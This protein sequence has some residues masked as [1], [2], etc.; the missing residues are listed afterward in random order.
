[1]IPT[2]LTRATLW[3]ALLAAC[4]TTRSTGDTIVEPPAEP[5]GEPEPE[6]EEVARSQ[7]QWTGV[8]VSSAERLFVNYPR[9]SDEV[10]ISVAELIDGLPRPYPSEQWNQWEEGAPLEQR[11]VAVQSVWCDSDDHLWVLDT[12][13]P[14]FNGVVE[15]APKLVEIDLE[16]DEVV[17][18]ISFAS[19]V[20]ESDSYLNDVRVSADGAQA[21]ITDSGAGALVV[22]DLETDSSRRLL[23]D[24]PSTQAEEVVLEIGGSPWLRGGEPPQVHADGIALDPFGGWLYYQPL[25]GR[26]LYRVPTSALDDPDLPAEELAARVEQVGETGASDGLVFAD[27][28]VLTSAIEHDAIRAVSPDGSFETLIHSSVLLWPDSFAA[29]PYRQ[30]YV[31]TSLIHLGPDPGEPYRIFRFTLP[32]LTP[33]DDD[34]ILPDT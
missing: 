29:G 6:L 18:T 17:R 14:Q 20:I 21:Y 27:D 24:H 2:T 31:T 30:I 12:G 7:H 4:G 34:G 10:P 5:P 8:A 15:G 22:V 28:H 23:A 13:N 1:M 3:L 16:S 19:P 9:W 32:D 33:T 26:H 11:W 25:T